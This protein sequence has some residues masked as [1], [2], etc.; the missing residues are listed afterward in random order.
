MGKTAGDIYDE[1][2]LSPVQ[3]PARSTLYPLPPMGVGTP[4]VESLTSYIARLADAHSIYSGILVNKLIAPL[5]PGYS[6]QKIQ[7]HLF[8]RDGY[9]SNLLNVPGPRLHYALQALQTLTLRTDLRH[10]TL[11]TLED[12]LYFGGWIRLTK[13]WCPAC[14]EEWRNSGQIVYDP[15]LWIVQELTVCIRHQRRLMLSCSYQDCAKQLPALAWRSR[16]GYC[17]YCQRWLGLSKGGEYISDAPIEER[18][19]VWQ[20]WVTEAL[21]A[22][23]AMAPNVAS[24]PT[25]QRVADG[26]NHLIQVMAEGN[27]TT[28]ARMLGI[29]P[30]MVGHWSRNGRLPRIGT[31][32]QLCYN[33]GLPLR[34]FLWKDASMLQPC[35]KSDAPSLT[36]L[37]RRPPSPI[38]RDKI[39]QELEHMLATEENP[40]PTLM[41]VAQK[42]GYSARVLYEC[43]P[44]ACYEISARYRVSVQRQ[45]EARMQRLREEFRQIALKLQAEGISLSRSHMTPFLSQEAILQDREAYALLKEVLRQVAED[46]YPSSSNSP[47]L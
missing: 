8:R 19:L 29:S 40:P 37:K 28:F 16:P 12:V 46:T 47:K 13:A 10:L 7:R 5:V 44:T 35:L 23:I 34:D 4:W 32:L 42:L 2:D 9:K 45:K 14:Y 41:S 22:V 36:L 30:N 21:G 38:N 6:P 31:L 25:R 11:L 18:E 3:I 33:L 43:H 20:Q 39:Y 15:L 1:W 24:F 27:V 26:V 17:P